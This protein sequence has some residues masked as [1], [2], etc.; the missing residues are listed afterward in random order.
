MQIKNALVVIAHPDDE[1]LGCAGLIRKLSSE[2]KQVSLMFLNN[3]CN[4]REDFD[5]ANIKSQINAV[6]DLLGASN[7]V[8]SN[9]ETAEFEK[10]SQNSFNNEVATVVKMFEI[11]T[12][13]THDSNDLHKDH[14]IVNE[15]AM[16]AGRFK[17]GS[18]VKNILTFP[19]ISSSDISPT[20]KFA[21]NLY[22]DIADH[23][24]TKKDAMK[25]YRT[26]YNEMVVNRGDDAI[27]TWARFFG[28]QS[29]HTY[30]EAY[31]IIRATYD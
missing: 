18:K 13:I 7:V 20:W 14:R 21:P 4:L 16:V 17:S 29:N 24:Q 31:R 25:L 11:D 22:V 30:A 10:Y 3:G 23:L 28:L 12:I 27:E 2:G 19:V 9:F 15:A 26:E 5:P 1:V 6:A 8:V